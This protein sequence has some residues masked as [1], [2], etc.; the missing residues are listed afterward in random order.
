MKRVAETGKPPVVVPVVV[1][2]ID[3]HVALI[4]PPVESRRHRTERHLCHCPSIRHPPTGGN[5][6]LGLYRIRH[7]QCLSAPYQV[8][9]FF[10]AVSAYIALS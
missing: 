6:L 2:V 8:S 4:V 3:V 9:S 1:V 5:G 7:L 10:N